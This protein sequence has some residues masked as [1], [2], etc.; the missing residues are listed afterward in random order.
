[1]FFNKEILSNVNSLLPVVLFSYFHF[2]CRL[3]SLIFAQTFKF[4]VAVIGEPVK[5]FKGAIEYS[6]WR[7][8]LSVVQF[9]DICVT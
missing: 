8:R 3:Y 4:D 7:G 5:G 1:M 9:T 6:E 2:N